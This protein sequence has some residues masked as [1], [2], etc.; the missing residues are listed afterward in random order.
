MPKV[1]LATRLDADIK[2]AMERY[3]T[4]H[5]VKIG[6]FLAEAIVDRLEELQDA[7]SAIELR[8]EP[9]ES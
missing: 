7:R 1:Q 5:G 9:A 3:C 6:H 8:R 2:Q 4:A